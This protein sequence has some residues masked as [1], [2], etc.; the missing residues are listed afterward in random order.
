MP[1][2][3]FENS[4]QYLSDLLTANGIPR[5]SAAGGNVE[6]VDRIRALI[7]ARNEARL[8]A[9]KVKGMAAELLRA[10]LDPATVRSIF[11][12]QIS[13]I[14]REELRAMIRITV[15]AGD[16]EEEV[17]DGLDVKM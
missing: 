3:E 14:I 1:N 12:A 15:D 2:Y 17:G 8:E 4:P 6:L 10:A 7:M 11:G 9:G 16:E 5:T 13:Q